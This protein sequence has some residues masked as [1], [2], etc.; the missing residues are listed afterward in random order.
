MLSTELLDII[1]ARY[2]YAN[3]EKQDTR[4]L[5]IP[6]SIGEAVEDDAEATMTWPRRLTKKPATWRLVEYN[7][8]ALSN[9]D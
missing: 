2:R 7:W 8:L 1:Y 3:D 9:E 4:G 5:V 6:E